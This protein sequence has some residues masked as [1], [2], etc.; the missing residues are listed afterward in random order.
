MR[1]MQ[2]LVTV[3]NVRQQAAVHEREVAEGETRGAAGDE[4]ADEHLREDGG[5]GHP[6]QE[7]QGARGRPRRHRSARSPLRDEDRGGEDGERHGEVPG[8]ELGRQP[9]DDDRAPEPRLDDD[10]QA[11]HDRS[12]E[13]R[14]VAT[15]PREERDEADGADQRSDEDRGHQA[16]TVLDPR[17]HFGRRDPVAQAQRPVRAGETG[18]GRAHQP[19][20]G[21]Q[22]ECRDGGRGR[23]LGKSGQRRFLRHARRA[24]WATSRG[25]SEQ[26]PP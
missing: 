7:D 4:R 26:A 11:R 3:S 19:T 18:I 9:L 15:A 22:H 16:V 25:I 23:Q 14:R 20:D 6:D 24:A 2:R 21:D 10:E 5:R 1:R 17:P 8:D 12:D 13:H